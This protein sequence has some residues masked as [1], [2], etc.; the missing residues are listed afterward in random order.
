MVACS[1]GGGAGFAAVLGEKCLAG[2]GAFFFGAGF[3]EGAFAFADGL[4]GMGVVMP[5]IDCP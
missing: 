3:L 2:A 1:I 5:G 4:A